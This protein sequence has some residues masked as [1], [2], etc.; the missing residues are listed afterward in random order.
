MTGRRLAA[1]ALGV[2]VAATGCGG[3][4]VAV[5]RSPWAEPARDAI[6]FWGHAC[7]YVDAAGTGVV[8]DPVF[9]RWAFPRHRTIAAPPPEAYRNTRLVLVSHAHND[10]LSPETIA[11]FPR[12]A[13][14]LC[15]APAAKYL[16]GV[17]QRVRVMRPGEALRV[18]AVRVIAVAAHHPGGRY[19]W[20][21]SDDGRALGW[22]IETPRATIYFTG[23]TN[24]FAG[25]REV[26]ERYRPDILLIDTNAHLHG[27]DAIL[28]ALDTGARVVV[29]IH[30]GAYG[31][32][33]L[34]APRR[35]RDADRFARV[36][37]PM[38]VELKPG[39]SLPLRRSPPAL[40]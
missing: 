8:T 26:G 34:P 33:G 1:L 39:A 38:Y 32:M 16:R 10:H 37:G 3:P 11:T 7:V 4:L 31:W 36:F 22:V 29:P 19:G 25:F 30:F 35:P 5:D 2:A 9:E 27:T 20:R 17:P 28:A 18:G 12:G 24:A 14:V 15:P 6:T 21:A 13:L 23:D 40:R